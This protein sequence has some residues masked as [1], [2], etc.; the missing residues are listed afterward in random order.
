MAYI[1]KLK[2]PPFDEGDIQL[3]L[4][5]HTTAVA[6]CTATNVIATTASSNK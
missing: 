5:Q 2:H 1:I 4:R 6:S 3:T